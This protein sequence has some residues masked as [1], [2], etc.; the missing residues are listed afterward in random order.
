MARR[1]QATSIFFGTSL[2]LLSIMSSLEFHFLFCVWPVEFLINLYHENLIKMGFSLLLLLLG[3]FQSYV[4]WVLFFYTQPL[5]FTCVITQKTIFMTCYFFVGPVQAAII[6]RCPWFYWSRHSQDSISQN[7]ATS[8][9]DHPS[10]LFSLMSPG[11]LRWV[12]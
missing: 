7:P 2:L 8:S 5:H 11:F 12:V 9:S 6:T 1:A 3:R 4:K 10:T